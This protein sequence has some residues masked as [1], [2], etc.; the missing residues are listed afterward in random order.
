MSCHPKH[1]EA[2]PLELPPLE[3]RPLLL[4]AGRLRAK[5]LKLRQIA[6]QM[7]CSR[8]TAANYLQEY[9]RHRFQ[10]LQAVAVDQLLDSILQIVAPSGDQESIPVKERL[11]AAR[12]LRLLLA[13]LPQLAD[14]DELQRQQAVEYQG[15]VVAWKEYAEYEEQQHRQEAAASDGHTPTNAW[16]S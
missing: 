15:R 4:E 8:G 16:T 10:L 7:G 1:T 13:S 3:R 11:H 12:E 2:E 6:E 14:H 9:E 5:G